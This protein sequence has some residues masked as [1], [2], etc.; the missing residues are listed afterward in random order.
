[1]NPQEFDLMLDLMEQDEAQREQRER[2]RAKAWRVALV[3]LAWFVV[4]VVGGV[5]IGC[6][7]VWPVELIGAN[8]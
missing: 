3:R 5:G 4:I 8:K 6:V 2:R 1:M 7:S